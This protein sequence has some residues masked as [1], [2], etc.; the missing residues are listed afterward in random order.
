LFERFD[1]KSANVIKR[2]GRKGYWKDGKMKGCKNALL[3]QGFGGRRNKK[4]SPLILY[5]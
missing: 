3:R 5:Y 2:R 1:F 4:T